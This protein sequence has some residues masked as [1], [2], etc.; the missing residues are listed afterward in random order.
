LRRAYCV[1]NYKKKGV[2][3]Q[4]VYALGIEYWVLRLLRPLYQARY[5]V[6]AMT[7]PFPL[8]ALQIRIEYWVLSIEH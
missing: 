4:F 6:L 3:C 1:F 5:R 2:S 7:F 8:C